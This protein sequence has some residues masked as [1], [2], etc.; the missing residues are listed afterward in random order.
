ML[1]WQR[2][3]ILQKK[4]SSNNLAGLVSLLLWEATTR[5]ANLQLQCDFPTGTL[6]QHL[7]LFTLSSQSIGYL[8][9]YR[10]DDQTSMRAKYEDSNGR[11]PLVLSDGQHQRQSTSKYQW[12]WKGFCGVSWNTDHFQ[13]TLSYMVIG[14]NQF[15]W[16]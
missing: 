16:K 2:S 7:Q 3:P 13:S 15:S 4:I 8:V 11:F 5:R 6:S 1:V 9:L 14:I 10:N 12:G